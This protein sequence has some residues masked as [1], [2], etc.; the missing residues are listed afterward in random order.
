MGSGST[1]AAA[2]FL[3]FRSIGLEKNKTYYLMARKAIPHLSRLSLNSN[4][5]GNLEE[6][7][8]QNSS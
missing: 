5:S 7:S 4:G 3:G 8:V 1:I 2:T 6:T